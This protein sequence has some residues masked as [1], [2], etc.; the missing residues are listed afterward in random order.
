MLPWGSL[1]ICQSN[2]AYSKMIY[3]TALF[4]S[5]TFGTGTV[6]FFYEENHL[7]PGVI[8]GYRPCIG[9]KFSVVEMQCLLIEM[10]NAFEFS[11]PLDGKKVR[12][13]AGGVMVPTL[14]GEA[15]KG[16]QLSLVVRVVD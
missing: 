16:G 11:L 14:E 12:R 13:Q 8:L 15:L 1:A 10:I 6:S 4:R 5:M 2:V 9:W 7:S 3:L